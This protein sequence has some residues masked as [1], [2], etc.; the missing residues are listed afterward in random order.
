MAKASR[1]FQCAQ[2]GAQ[3][4]KWAGRCA[5]C[6][7]F[8]TIAE[9]A[10]TV[11]TPGLRASTTG[12]TPR[13]P[14]RPIR[15]ALDA[16]PVERLRSGIGEFDRAL[17]GG[18]VPGQVV[19]CSGPP[20]SGK[21]TLLLAVADAMARATNAPVLYISGEES[22]EQ[23]AIRAHR[24]GATGST[25]LVADD[26]DLAEVIGHIDEA[27]IGGDVA[28]V[29]IDSVQT[30]A[31]S[32]VEG[33]A[34][35]VTQV[36]EV[37][38]A[39]TRV[40]KSR[41]IPVIIVGQVTKD[42]NVAGPRALE[43]IVD[44][45][46]S[47]DGD[48]HTSLRLLRTV[49]N[50]FGALEVAAFEQTDSGMQEVPD[51][52]ALF[53]GERE[54]AVP[55][56]CITV[57]IEGNRAIIAEVQALVAGAGTPNPRRGVSGLD[58]ARSAMLVAVAERAA[59]LRLA[60]KDVYLATLAGMRLSDPAS[61]LAVC[62]A[63]VSASRSGVVPLDTAAIGEVTLSGDVRGVPMIVERVSEAVRLGYR[64]VLV[65]KGSAQRAN[66]RWAKGTLIEIGSLADAVRASAGLSAN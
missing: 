12:Q 49:K 26:T 35:G 20:G 46:L 8:G 1:T 64:T 40:A 51:P 42:S 3:A 5:K 31:S 48:A 32:N 16:R 65:P 43:H 66:G 34:G 39:L 55:G 18:L 9:V 6:G 62:L 58:S 50:R 22:V 28:L 60:D 23:V 56:T 27:S 2:C 17:G 11:A 59:G 37:A 10:P 53:R 30:I 25:L 38:Q 54:H 41:G 57:T 36:M 24:L 4:V 44:A 13:R 63:V 21:S 45:H 61:D 29:V 52:S 47:L 19:L 7:E 14:A 33:R 15:E